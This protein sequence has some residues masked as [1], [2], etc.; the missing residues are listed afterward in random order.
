[1]VWVEMWLWSVGVLKAEGGVLQADSPPPLSG[2]SPPDPSLSSLSVNHSETIVHHIN[3]KTSEQTPLAPAP[4]PTPAPAAQSAAA[5][6][7]R[8]LRVMFT[9]SFMS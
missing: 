6:P 5:G 2:F 7:R 4:A 1:M 3:R 8:A 9:W